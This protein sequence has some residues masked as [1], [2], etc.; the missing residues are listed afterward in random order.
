[1]VIKRRKNLGL[2]WSNLYSSFY[3]GDT[4]CKQP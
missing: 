2:S 4:P 1:M 3:A